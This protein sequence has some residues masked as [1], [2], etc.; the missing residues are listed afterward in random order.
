MSYTVDHLLSGVQVHA[1]LRS[2]TRVMQSP[3]CAHVLR[4]LGILRMHNTILK[5]Y[6]FSDCAEHIVGLAK[7]LLMGQYGSYR[8]AGEYATVYVTVYVT[9]HIEIDCYSIMYLV[10]ETFY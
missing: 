8:L 7:C 4:N 6:K 9:V 1:I 5:L 3:D 10:S 2:C